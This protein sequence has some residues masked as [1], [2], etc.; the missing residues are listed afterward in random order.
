VPFLHVVHKVTVTYYIIQ[1]LD[2]LN[3]VEQ[4]KTWITI[5][6][7]LKPVPIL[8]DDHHRYCLHGM[9]FHQYHVALTLSTE[10]SKIFAP[11]VIISLLLNVISFSHNHMAQKRAVTLTK[12]AL[13]MVYG[14]FD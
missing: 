4:S 3:Y 5:S 7:T 14:N 1:D 9:E 2:Y 10:M 11:R 13:S 6:A 8:S 12:A